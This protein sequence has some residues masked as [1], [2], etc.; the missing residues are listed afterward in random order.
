MHDAAATAKLHYSSEH[1]IF[2]ENAIFGS[3][4]EFETPSGRLCNPGH[5]IE[6]SWF[7]LHLNKMLKDPELE[8][9]ALKTL[10]GNTWLPNYVFEKLL[11]WPP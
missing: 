6:V 11:M 4:V 9:L 8:K 3:G 7:L 10:Q 2:M 1:N 5:S